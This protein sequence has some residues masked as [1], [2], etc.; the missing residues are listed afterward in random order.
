MNLRLLNLLTVFF[1]LEGLWR[2]DIEGL[3]TLSLAHALD[4][5]TRHTCAFVF[6]FPLVSFVFPCSVS[7]LLNF[8][9]FPM[10]FF[11]HMND[12]WVQGGGVGG[13][14]DLYPFI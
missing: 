7:P 6:V 11:L 13:K 5:G 8:T 12:I 1:F 4:E 9:Y 14:C 10:V 3:V 2:E